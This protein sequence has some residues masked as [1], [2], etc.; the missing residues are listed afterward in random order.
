MSRNA[1]TIEEIA[2]MAH[3]VNAFYCHITGDDSATPWNEAPD[4]QKD[5]AIAGVKFTLQYPDA[6]PAA[7]HESWMALKASE[8]WTYGEKKDPEQKKHPCMVPY[9][10]LPI[11]QQRKDYLFA[12]VVKALAHGGIYQ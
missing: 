10:Q 8:G 4:W 1:L 12:A 2:R 11:H 3:E 7:Q 6:G 5:S 9:D